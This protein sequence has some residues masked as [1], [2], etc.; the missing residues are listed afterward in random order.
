M[1]TRRLTIFQLLGIDIKLDGSWIFLAILVTWSLAAGY[2]PQQHAGLPPFT[3]WSMGILGALGL[4]AS[5][6]FHELGHSVIA[7]RF[8]IPIKDITLFIFG[9][10]AS[11]E[12]EPPNAKSEFSM[13]IAGPIVSLVLCV[14]FLFIYSFTPA[15]AVVPALEVI[16]WL[17]WINGLL[18]GF[19]L[20][21]AFPLDGGRVLRAA[22]WALRNNL[23]WATRVAASIGSMFG[24]LLIAL[25]I[26]QIIGGMWIGGLW[27]LMLGLFMRSA[28]SMSYRQVLFRQ[29]LEGE[30]VRRF[31]KT[32]PI[33]VPRYI[34][35]QE[36]V[37]AY[38][39][40]YHFKT[41]PVVDGDHLV[42]CVSVKD[43]RE[44]PR[45]EWPNLPVGEVMCECSEE[46][47]VLPDEDAM[48][49]LLKMNNTGNS[50]LLVTQEGR[51]VGIV[52]LKDLLKFLSLKLDLE[53]K[54]I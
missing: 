10:V 12:D 44:V 32:D 48:N 54:T 33:T 15:G 22:L 50:R 51:L 42:G 5:I 45:D 7:R 18:A 25:G 11:M 16:G 38:I 31:M 23:R 43:V 29:A 37:D 27:A 2:F 6:I 26:F 30:R 3:Y 47:S 49:A 40:K 24:L 35:I 1:F 39:Y 34:S 28:S 17:G 4:F 14:V 20:I 53:E 36:L 41:Y 52:A 21:P 9:G 19:N 46:N 8:G 13:A